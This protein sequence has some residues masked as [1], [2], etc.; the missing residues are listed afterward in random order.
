MKCLRK[1]LYK[2]ILQ[3][4]WKKPTPAH[5]LA[6]HILGEKGLKVEKCCHL[7]KPDIRW[8]ILAFVKVKYFLHSLGPSLLG[9]GSKT[10]VSTTSYYKREVDSFCPKY[11][12]QLLKKFWNC[13]LHSVQDALNQ[14]QFFQLETFLSI[15]ILR[16]YFLHAGFLPIGKTLYF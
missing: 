7:K 16:W 13:F 14:E 10:Q 15:Q 8:Y 2:Y 6:L 5:L 11:F 4:F 12:T 3:I 1:L 9:T